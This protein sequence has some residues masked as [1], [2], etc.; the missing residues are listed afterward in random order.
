[1]DY[2][3]DIRPTIHTLR[4]NFPNNNS[5]KSYLSILTVI[6]SNLPSLK[7]NYQTLTKLD[8]NVNKTVQDLQDESK[9]EDYEK[10][11]IIDSDRNIILK[12]LNLLSNIKDKK[13]NLKNLNLLSNIKGKLIFAVYTLQPAR[14][15]EWRH[16]VLTT[17]TDKKGT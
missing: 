13:H 4:S 6:T 1:M 12:K 2:L 17:E 11:K 7:D 14:R 9:L 5:F 16:V 10:D 8:I 3:K 15:L